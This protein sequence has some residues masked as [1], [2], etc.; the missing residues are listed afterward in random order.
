MEGA[1]MNEVAVKRPTL[2]TVVAVLTVIS[3]VLSVIAGFLWLFLPP[4]AS[5]NGLTWRLVGIVYLIVGVVELA[6]ARGL[7]RGNPTARIVFAVT[8]AVNLIVSLGA[9]ISSDTSRGLSFV[10]VVLV[11]VALVILYTPK[12]NAF[13]GRRPVASTV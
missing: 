12:A 2:V 4:D 5:S 8:M 3:G 9:A 10:D 13:F 1:V 7:L 11:I 6:V